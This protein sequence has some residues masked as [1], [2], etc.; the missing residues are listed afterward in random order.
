MTDTFPVEGDRESFGNDE[1]KEY[2]VGSGTKLTEV[3]VEV[4]LPRGSEKVPAR[5]PGDAN[6][7]WQG[8]PGGKREP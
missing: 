7:G 6:F 4:P 3:G 1:R 2:S 5:Q 8:L